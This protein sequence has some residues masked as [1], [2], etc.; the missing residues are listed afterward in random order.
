MCAACKG[1]YRVDIFGEFFIKTDDGTY[2]F[3]S[4]ACCQLY[5]LNNDIDEIVMKPAKVAIQ[6]QELAGP[7]GSKKRINPWAVGICAGDEAAAKLLKQNDEQEDA[8]YVEDSKFDE[9]KDYEGKG[10]HK[11]ENTKKKVKKALC[12][13]CQNILNNGQNWS[14]KRHFMRHHETVEFNES[15]VRLFDAADPLVAASKPKPAVE[16]KPV[17]GRNPRFYCE[18]CGGPYTPKY[19]LKRHFLANHDGIF[20]DAVESR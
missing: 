7:S 11:N 8:D 10:K 12:L 19:G 17:P 16:S 5:R 20:N 3:C 2:D 13:V 18:E 4:E 14:L 6:R 9:D 1:E 15:L